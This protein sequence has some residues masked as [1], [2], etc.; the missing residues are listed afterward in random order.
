MHFQSAI[1]KS[2]AGI[3][4]RIIDIGGR[5]TFV[6]WHRNNLLPYVF[7]GLRTRKATKPESAGMLDWFP[8]EYFNAAKIHYN[9]K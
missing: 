2:E 8:I 7:D 9:L 4:V 3:A 1:A 6:I 5:V